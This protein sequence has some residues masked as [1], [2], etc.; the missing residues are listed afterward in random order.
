AEKYIKVVNGLN[1]D[2]PYY[3]RNL[4]ALK[5]GR[6]KESLVKTLSTENIR[7][8]PLDSHSARIAFVKSCISEGEK[9]LDLGCGEGRYIQPILKIAS[10][11][12]GVDIN[13]EVLKTAEKKIER[14]NIKNAELYNSLD[15]EA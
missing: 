10:Y 9:V 6:G 4:L 15:F 1:M 3:P 14:N 8:Q 12:Y 11:Y 7:L 2:M 13:E 5:L